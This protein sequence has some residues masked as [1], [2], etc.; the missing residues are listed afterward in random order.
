VLG[1]NGRMRAAADGVA[2]RPALARRLVGGDGETAFLLAD[3]K[4]TES[5]HPILLTQ[6]D[7]REVQLA[8]GAMAAGV[9]MLLEEFGAEIGDV[10]EV[11]LA[12]AFGNF[13]RPDRALAIGLLPRV[14]AGKV[15]F[16]GNAAGAGARMLLANRR[17][18]EVADDVARGVEHVELSQRPDFQARFADAMFFPAG[19]A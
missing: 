11:L 13:I 16:V 9:E 15:K 1:A 19:K 10:E 8:K 4:E 3:K 6:Q 12:G 18:R 17:L 5:G 2:G 7:V 14:P